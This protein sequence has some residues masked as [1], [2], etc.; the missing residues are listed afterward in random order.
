MSMER[1]FKKG[2]VVFIF[3]ADMPDSARE[4]EVAAISAA[5]YGTPKLR[6]KGETTF[7]WY[8]N[9][10]GTGYGRSRLLAKEDLPQAQEEARLRLARNAMARE[11]ETLFENAAR[12][13]RRRLGGFRGD[14]DFE[15][16]AELA[17]K[18]RGD[19]DTLL[20]TAGKLQPKATDSAHA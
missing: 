2:D 3:N 6:L 7:D 9:G 12:E 4:T 14:P 1:L 10:G 16:M 5:K 17:N 13:A 11:I 20:R 18:L 8:A 15:S 19:L